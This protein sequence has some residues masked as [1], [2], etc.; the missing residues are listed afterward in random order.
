VLGNSNSSEPLKED[1][2]LNLELLPVC[3]QQLFLSFDLMLIFWLSYQ[4]TLNGYAQSKLVAE[5]LVH[6][7]RQQHGLIATVFRPSKQKQHHE[8]KTLMMRLCSHEGM[9]AHSETNGNCNMSD[10]VQ[11]YLRSCMIVKAFPHLEAGDQHALDW[12]SVTYCAKA[13]VYV[14]RSERVKPI[15]SEIVVPRA[16]HLVSGDKKDM[17]SIPAQLKLIAEGEE[18]RFDYDV[19]PYDEWLERVRA[20]PTEKNPLASLMIVFENG[21]PRFDARLESSPTMECLL[22]GSGIRA[23][24]LNLRLLMDYLRRHIG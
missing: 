22:E 10:W 24:K 1:S 4:K 14:S 20:L 12:V 13:I 15:G 8:I 11:R 6:K 18:G 3:R 5:L 9:I 23:L 7:A 19:L 17:S 2:P 16:L 21:F